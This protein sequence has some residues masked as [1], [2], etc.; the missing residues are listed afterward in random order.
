M[1][2]TLPQAIIFFFFLSI[3]ST[4]GYFMA[5]FVLLIRKVGHLDQPSQDTLKRHCGTLPASFT[6]N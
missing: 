3:I 1:C 4:P 6:V 5:F 2:N